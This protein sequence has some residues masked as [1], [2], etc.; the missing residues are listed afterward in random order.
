MN[1]KIEG[2]INQLLN[3]DAVNYFETSERLVLMNILEKEIISE[4]EKVSLYKIIEK[5][6]R[7]IKN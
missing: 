2:K 3:S 5:Y 7:F 4:L 6:K 1:K